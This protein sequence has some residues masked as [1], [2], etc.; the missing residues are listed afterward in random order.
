MKKTLTLIFVTAI[1]TGIFVSNVSAEND[2]WNNDGYR[3]S[4]HIYPDTNF[5]FYLSGTNIDIN[6]FCSNRFV[7]WNSVSNYETQVASLLTAFQN[8]YQVLVKY[9]HDNTGCA[10]NVEMF[11]IKIE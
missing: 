9:D 11:K 8:G 3:I 10:T 7:I 4:T 6:S 5:Q 2:L 1:L